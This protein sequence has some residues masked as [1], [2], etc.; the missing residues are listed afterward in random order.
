M[1]PYRVLSRVVLPG[2]HVLVKPG[3]QVRMVDDAFVAR[4]IG[5]PMRPLWGPQFMAQVWVTLPL[6]SQV[7]LDGVVAWGT[8][9]VSMAHISGESKPVRRDLE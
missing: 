7:P 1:R 9:G 5:N 4:P 8:A 6:P 3:E 2:Q